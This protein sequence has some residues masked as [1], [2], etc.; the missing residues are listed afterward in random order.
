MVRVMSRPRLGAV[1]QRRGA[2]VLLAVVAVLAAACRS[3]APVDSSAPLATVAP[4]SDVTANAWAVT[5]AFSDITAAAG[6]DFVHDNGMTGALYFPEIMG[7][8]GAMFDYDNDGDQDLLL[9]QGSPLRPPPGTPASTAPGLR[10]G[11]GSRLYRNDL[12]AAAGEPRFT[13]VTAASGLDT[14]GRYGMGVATADYDNDGDVDIYLTNWGPNQLWRN[15]GDGS[16]SDV[17]A[18]AGVDDPRWSSSASWLDFDRDGWLDLYVGNYVDFTY[19]NHHPCYSAAGSVDYCSP[20]AY[21]PEPDKLLRNRGDGSFEDVSARMGIAS[22]PGPA[23]GVVASDLDGDGWVDVYV[24]NDQAENFL[25]LNQGGQRFV[26]QAPMAGAA[27]SGG[28]QPQ[29]SMGLL[30][31]DFDNDGDDD[32]WATNLRNEGS[33]LYRNDGG[34]LFEDDTARRGLAAASR[35]FTGFGTSDADIDH[36][37]WPDIVQVNGEV[38]RNREQAAAGDPFPFKQANLVF[39]NLGQGQFADVTAASGAAFGTPA[40]G[41][42]LATGDIDN[43]GDDDLLVTN[44]KGPAQ[45]LRNEAGAAHPWLGLRLLTA[46]GKRDALGAVARLD[47]PAA[48]APSAGA[49]ATGPLRRRSHTDGSYASAGDPRLRFG[50]GDSTGPQRVVVT[51]PDGQSEAWADLAPGQYH[52]LTQGQGLR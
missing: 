2:G 7:S 17:T 37:G 11:G 47:R 5:P 51:W 25:W 8:G 26:N 35:P 14:T 38:V 41:R 18:A 33:T 21:R 16:F 45:L 6:L 30:A 27:V 3:S 31:A 24:A 39:R 19:D 40:V 42:G 4:T 50:L 29:A 48:G 34:G 12:S 13:D 15:N 46:D 52:V 20:K 49:P 9:V 22:S 36:D 23:L 1:R 32:L 44:N 43:D 28:G 10:A